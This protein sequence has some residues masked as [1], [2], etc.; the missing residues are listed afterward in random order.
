MRQGVPWLFFHTGD[1]TGVHGTQKNLGWTGDQRPGPGL[2]T[3]TGWAEIWG[4]KK[5]RE[6]KK[7]MKKT[8]RLRKEGE[9]CLACI[10]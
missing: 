6:L 3:R 8:R 7:G 9:T 1:K 2:E 10:L 4:T 5:R